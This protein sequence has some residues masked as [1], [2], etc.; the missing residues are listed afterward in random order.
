MTAETI[1]N[2]GEPSDIDGKMDADLEHMIQRAS[3]PNLGSLFRKGKK[4]GLI[5]PGMAYGQTA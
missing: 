4:S 5:K 2:G 3:I 1:A